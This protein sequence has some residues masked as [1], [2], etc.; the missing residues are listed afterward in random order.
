MKNSRS[1][2]YEFLFHLRTPLASIR[3]AAQMADHD[4]RLGSPVPAEARAWIGKWGPKIDTW[5][6]EVMALSALCGRS[7][8][9]DHD[10]KKLIQD[11]IS[12]LDGVEVAAKEASD[13]PFSVKEESDQDGPHMVCRMIINSIGYIHDHYKAM[14]ELLPALS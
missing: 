9:E 5:L 1:E 4:E 8:S 10:W 13:I 6:D 3:G 7:K 14:Q 2:L 11:L 12:S